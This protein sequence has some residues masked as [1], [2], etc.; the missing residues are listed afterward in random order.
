[1]KVLIGVMA[2]TA[3]MAVI[4][5]C[6]GTSPAVTVECTASQAPG[7]VGAG[8]ATFKIVQAV[9]Y[10][11]PGATGLQPLSDVKM[12]IVSPY[13]DNATICA[14]TCSVTGVFS[15]DT[16]VQTDANGILIFTVKLTGGSGNLSG[17]LIEVADS[18]A[19]TSCSVPITISAAGP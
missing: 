14:G 6:G 12:R 8:P 3:A 19:A 9:S 17:S 13:P 5:G 10:T 15:P 18:Q 1:M 7:L 16:K 2:A 4:S 11:D